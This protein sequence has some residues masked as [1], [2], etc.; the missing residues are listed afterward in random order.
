M[1]IASTYYH[2]GCSYSRPRHFD[3]ALLYFNGSLQI[4]QL[5]NVHAELGEDDEALVDYEKFMMAKTNRKELNGVLRNNATELFRLVMI[6][7]E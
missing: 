5:G 2:M 4:R 3:R 6:H 7:K 1:S